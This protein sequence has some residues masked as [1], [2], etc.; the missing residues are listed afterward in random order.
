MAKT[1]VGIIGCGNISGIY[2]QNL[3]RFE[4][5]ELAACADIDVERA[6][7]R[8]LEHQ[9]PKACEVAEL[10][11]DPSIAAVANLT[12]PK[13]H[14]EV[15][16]AVLNAGKH[17]YNEKPFCAELDQAQKLLALARSKNLLAGGA[18]DTFL[19]GGL[20]TCRKLIDEGAIGKPIGAAGY[21]LCHGHEGWHPD[22]AFYYQKG[23]GPLFDMGPYYL[24][25][26]VALLGPLKRVS[27]SVTASFAERVDAK[28]RVTKVETPT[29]ILGLLEFA[30][31]AIGSLATSFDVW[32][33]EAPFIEIYGTE[34]SLS[35]PDPNNFG[36][37]P[38]I[39]KAKDS[40]W[41]DLPLSFGYAENSRGLGLADLVSAATAKHP[42]RAGAD[43][44]SHVLEAMHGILSSAETGKHQALFSSCERPRPLPQGLK[45][46][47][48]D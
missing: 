25:A 47:S 4:N 29:H 37:V 34:G 15:A 5:L 17:V 10:L 33:A 27:G 44:A 21:M 1:K 40:Q 14:F 43:M 16:L 22:P 28:G 38:R 42:A 48:I 19:G 18:P 35:L 13:A 45:D 30:S 12:I 20:Q 23:G 46:W 9:I 7:A 36:G 2:C 8:A 26:M 3:K 41:Q 31:G 32:H 6:K 39:R 24:T 11:A